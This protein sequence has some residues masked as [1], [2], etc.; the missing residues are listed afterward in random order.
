MVKRFDVKYNNF[1]KS[2]NGIQNTVKNDELTLNDKKAILYDFGGLEEQTWKLFKYYLE[3]V[4]GYDNLGGASKTV[5]REA[6][7]VGLISEEQC[8]LLL[9]TIDLRN[10]LFHEYNYEEIEASCNKIIQY[11]DLFNE[12]KGV[13]DDL[14][15]KYN[16]EFE[17]DLIKF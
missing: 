2:L 9:E 12:V 14:K 3:Y 1:V 4:A 7:K 10:V 13:F 8:R 5:Y 11:L 16:D 15:L 17:K 6:K